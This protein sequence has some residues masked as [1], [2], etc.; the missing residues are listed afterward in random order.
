MVI[1]SMRIP[2]I[3]NPIPIILICYIDLKQTSF[4]PLPAY[5]SYSPADNHTQWLHNNLPEGKKC[6]KPCCAKECC[7]PSCCEP[8]CCTGGKK[9][10]KTCCEK[11][12]CSQGQACCSTGLWKERC[13]KLV[14]KQRSFYITMPFYAILE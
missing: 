11:G 1:M 12:C 6:T 2:N 5:Q 8:G 3:I 7:T 14:L 4:P 13:L 9:C 10:E